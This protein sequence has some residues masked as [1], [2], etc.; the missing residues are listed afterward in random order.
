M[1]YISFLKF[2]YYFI[3]GDDWTGPVEHQ[4]R[5]LLPAAA[6]G[7]GLS[8]RQNLVQAHV[9]GQRPDRIGFGRGVNQTDDGV[10]LVCCQP[11]AA[12]DPRRRRHAL[13]LATEP[14]H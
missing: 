1:R 3:V 12:L 6:L 4:A 14:S 2:W 13:N 7:I 5:W 9:L 10:D 8:L 11:G